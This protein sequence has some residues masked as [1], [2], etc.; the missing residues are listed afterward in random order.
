M[1]APATAPFAITTPS[2][3]L[4]SG[5]TKPY[6]EYFRKLGGKWCVVLNGWWFDELARASVLD[7]Q[8]KV[9]KGEVLPEE[10]TQEPASAATPVH[11]LDWRQDVKADG[12]R[13]GKKWL[14]VEEEALLAAL[15]KGYDLK[16]LVIEHKR[17]E[18]SLRTRLGEIA[19]RLEAEG[20]SEYEIIA[21]TGLS[22]EQLQEIKKGIRRKASVRV[23]P[24]IAS[25]AATPPVVAIAPPP[26]EDDG[27]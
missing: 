26:T 6:R 13:A 17:T 27:L 22:R 14:P 9:R 21:S 20:K 3:F 2:G 8:E 23:A 7:L 10:G 15:Q 1:S 16:T 12:T 11:S 25:P 5:D 24:V 4:V 18:S 19:L